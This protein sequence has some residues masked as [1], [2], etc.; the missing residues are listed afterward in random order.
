MAL[1]DWLERLSKARK[2][3]FEIKNDEPTSTGFHRGEM[4]RAAIIQKG[5]RV[6]ELMNEVKAGDCIV[7]VD[8][9]P[10]RFF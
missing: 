5:R 1:V 2:V 8:T 9:I 4:L 7:H 6:H 3:W 10:G